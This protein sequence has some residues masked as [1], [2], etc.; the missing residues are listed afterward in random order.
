[1][2]GDPGGALEV[3]IGAARASARRRCRF[4]SWPVAGPAPGCCDGPV[5][6]VRPAHRP[7]N[8]QS[9][10][11]A[12]RGVEPSLSTLADQVRACTIVLNP[13]YEALRAHVLAAARIHGDDTP[14]PVRRWATWHRPIMDLR[15]RRPA[16]RRAAA[17]VFFYS[18]DR[19]GEHSA[20]SPT[21]GKLSRPTP[22]P[23]S[24]S[25]TMAHVGRA[26]SPKQHAGRTAGGTSSNWPTRRCARRTCYRRSRSRQ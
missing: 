20:I 13:L 22:M 2:E 21:S 18:P 15:A 4:T 16:V 26:R 3:H 25:S 24:T 12:R 19:R 11:Y 23:A 14:V 17:E 5:R 7:I 1:V 8:R 6:E 9:Q 10:R